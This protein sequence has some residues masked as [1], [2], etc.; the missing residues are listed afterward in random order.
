[1]I[2]AIPKNKLRAIQAPREKAKV[3]ATAVTLNLRNS[4]ADWV[5]SMATHP[6]IFSDHLPPTY[7]ATM[8]SRARPEYLSALGAA[9]CECEPLARQQHSWWLLPVSRFVN[10]DLEGKSTGDTYI[11]PFSNGPHIFSRH[12]SLARLVSRR[13]RPSSA[14]HLS[15]PSPSRRLTALGT[16]T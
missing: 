5:L 14:R 3:F 15:L 8:N 10:C 2:H 9:I 12:L 6:R 13:R 7:P 1:M 4:R 16:T 11:H